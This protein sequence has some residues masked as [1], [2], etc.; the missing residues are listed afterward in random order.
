M[1]A[2]NAHNPMA[3]IRE[4]RAAQLTWF[5]A[6]KRIVNDATEQSIGF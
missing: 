4:K 2:S 1:N 3:S 6:R 5:H